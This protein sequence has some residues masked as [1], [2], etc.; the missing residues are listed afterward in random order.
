M[1]VHVSVR[2]RAYVPAEGPGVIMVPTS[3]PEALSMVRWILLLLT[4]ATLVLP[5]WV[6]TSSWMTLGI[7]MNFLGGLATA[8]AFAQVHIAERS[9]T[10]V[11]T[12]SELDPLR[13]SSTRLTY[14]HGGA[15]PRRQTSPWMLLFRC[16]LHCAQP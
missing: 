3:L 4:F 16:P 8:P 12:T 15:R 1:H 2:S 13:R 6:P 11:V 14:V 10:E 9:R 5:A 7:G